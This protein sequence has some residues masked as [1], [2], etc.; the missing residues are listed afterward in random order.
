MMFFGDCCL[1]LFMHVGFGLCCK[2]EII[3]VVVF[4]SHLVGRK[5]FYIR[6]K[7]MYNLFILYFSIVLFF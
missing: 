5:Y 2:R 3:F 7:V 4:P 6:R 1:N